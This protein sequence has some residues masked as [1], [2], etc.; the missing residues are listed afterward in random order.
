MIKFY[1]DTDIDLDFPCETNINGICS[2]TTTLE[3]CSEICKNNENCQY[4]TFSNGICNAVDSNFYPK[5]NPLL[6]LMSRAG[7][8]TIIK[9]DFET[10]YNNRLFYYDIVKIKDITNDIILEPPITFMHNIP[11]L[12]NKKAITHISSDEL[13]TFSND[14]ENT[15]LIPETTKVSWFKKYRIPQYSFYIVPINNINNKD[16]FYT[17]VFEIITPTNGKLCNKKN[18]NR[19]ENLLI[20]NDKQSCKFMFILLERYSK[21]GV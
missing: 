4:A 13:V 7:S 10:D 9:N 15:I 14:T 18:N 16:L 1:S 20:S 6:H 3:E 12:Y 8:T 5:L 19:L 21:F 17:D 11:F 2:N